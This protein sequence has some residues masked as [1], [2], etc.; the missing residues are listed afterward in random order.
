MTIEDTAKPSAAIPIVP[1]MTA[2]AAVT[3]LSVFSPLNPSIQ[4]MTDFLPFRRPWAI[5][6]LVVVSN[7]FIVIV[8][9]L[10]SKYVTSLDMNWLGRAN[11]F[12]T[13]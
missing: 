9:K 1:T 10:L 2:G 11:I 4:P 13:I 7:A 8:L 12:I 6:T 5:C 3:P